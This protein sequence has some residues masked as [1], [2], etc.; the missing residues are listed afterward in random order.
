MDFLENNYH[1]CIEKLMVYF[2]IFN[3]MKIAK[4][5]IA[6][7]GMVFAFSFAANAQTSDDETIAFVESNSIE[8]SLEANETANIETINVWPQVSAFKIM[9]DVE[10]KE[11]NVEIYNVAGRLV[12]T[13][14]VAKGQSIS[15]ETLIPGAYR[16][17]VGNREGRFTKK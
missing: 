11:E 3:T 4:S 7:L 2:V 6:T 1:I 15:I 9:V 13:E 16:V 14:K 5:F 12:K 8:E 10:G 17:K